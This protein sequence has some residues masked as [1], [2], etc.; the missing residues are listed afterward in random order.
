MGL[1]KNIRASPVAV[2]TVG[3]R[4]DVYWGP[5]DEWLGAS[6][7][8]RKSAHWKTRWPHVAK[9]G[10]IYVN[11]IRARRQPDSQGRPNDIPRT[12]LAANGN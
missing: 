2:W 1:E 4:G 5:E 7:Y 8:R 6:V 12:P 10:L 3:N 9:L 11:P